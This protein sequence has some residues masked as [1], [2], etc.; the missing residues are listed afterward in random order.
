MRRRVFKGESELLEL[1]VNL[2]DAC[3]WPTM[4]FSTTLSIGKVLVAIS[5]PFF[6][7]TNIL[8]R[9]MEL[10]K[11]TLPFLDVEHGYSC[12]WCISNFL[13][14]VRFWKGFWVSEDV[15]FLGVENG[16]DASSC[17]CFVA[18]FLSQLC[19][20]VW[21][22]IYITAPICLS[23]ILCRLE[24]L[25]ECSFSSSPLSWL[26]FSFARYPSSSA[27]G[28]LSALLVLLD[29]MLSSIFMPLMNYCWFW[30][31]IW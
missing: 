30:I 20:E 16:N 10:V 4:F 14:S 3:S 1:L 12:D 17:D 26:L 9:G 5:L 19:W 28:F 22:A 23:F 25:E 27:F 29:F 31:W 24:A 2:N 11:I 18:I 8:L 7:G 6:F 15:V 21:V 13:L